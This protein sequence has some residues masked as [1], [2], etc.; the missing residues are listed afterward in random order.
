MSTST[1]EKQKVDSPAPSNAPS[2]PSSRRD[3]LKYNSLNVNVPASSA[4]QPIAQR[5]SVIPDRSKDRIEDE[6]SSN[7]DSASEDIN[8]GT[9]RGLST[10]IS[11]ERK[12]DLVD[13]IEYSSSPRK[14][15]KK[16]AQGSIHRNN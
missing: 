14:F 8:N 15:D 9:N 1:K 11:K 13:S 6:T 12:E 3:S 2:N 4:A 7:L 16:K 5:R 10:P